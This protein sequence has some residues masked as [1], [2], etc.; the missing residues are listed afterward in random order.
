M[1]WIQKR[2]LH[3]LCISQV[4]RYSEMQP[5]GVDG[6]LFSY[7]LKQLINEDLVGKS[8]VGYELTTEGKRYTDKLSFETLNPRMQPKILTVVACQNDAGEW[9]MHKRR[10]QF[11]GKLSFISGKLHYGERIE[12]AAI[13]EVKEKT[14][15][16]VDV[17]RL[18]ELYVVIEQDGETVSHMLAHVFRGTNPG[19]T[20]HSPERIGECFWHAV[21]D[22]ADDQYVPWLRDLYRLA[23]TAET[24]FFEQVTYVKQPDGSL[25][26]QNE[27]AA[28]T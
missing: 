5:D 26:V 28:T 16:D 8:E 23:T 18:G 3:K 9:L 12:T 21:D 10:R 1:H 25:R 19:G 14:S 15:L 11:P 24:P 17:E 2:I 6:N 27:V 22:P 7:H 20:L 13:R 4:A